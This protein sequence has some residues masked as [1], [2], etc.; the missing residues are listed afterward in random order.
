M[1]FVYAVPIF[2]CLV[3][4]LIVLMGD[5]CAPIVYIYLLIHRAWEHEP[6]VQWNWNRTQSILSVFLNNIS[7]FIFQDAYFSIYWLGTMSFAFTLQI[8]SFQIIHFTYKLIV[9]RFGVRIALTI[10]HKFTLV[11]FDRFNASMINSIWSIG[12][13]RE[14]KIKATTTTTKN[15]INI[16]HVIQFCTSFVTLVFSLFC[17]LNMNNIGKSLDDVDLWSNLYN[18]IHWLLD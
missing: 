10:A 11:Q 3:F 5:C 16:I 7:R 1:A 8:I 18:S 2:F 12:E 9:L 4:I 6:S 13:E 17:I 14:K 15:D